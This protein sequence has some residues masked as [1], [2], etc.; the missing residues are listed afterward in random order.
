MINQ[1]FI[2]AQEERELSQEHSIN[3]SERGPA[4]MMPRAKGRKNFTDNRLDD[5]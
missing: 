5:R 2:I 4:K 1:Y 3:N